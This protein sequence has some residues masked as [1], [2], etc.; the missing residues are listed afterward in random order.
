MNLAE[1]ANPIGLLVGF[2]LTL[3]V[4][5]YIFGDNPLFR[6]A[7]H[8]FIGVAAAYVTVLVVNNIVWNRLLKPVISGSADN[9]SLAI[10]SLLLGAWLMVKV[11]PRL[12][13]FGSPVLAYLVGVGAATAIGGAVVGTIVPQVRASV[14]LV[15]FD[16]ASQAG[17]SRVAWF[18]DA[19]LIL[20]GT[21]TTLAFFHFGARGRSAQPAQQPRVA[22]WLGQ[23]GQIF[24]AVTFGALFAGVYGAALAALVERIAFIWNT[25]WD[26]LGSYLP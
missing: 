6:V 13:R 20:V 4:L 16:I 2:F 21:V 14:N 25:I 3:M 1:L 5:S 9:L 15:D 11:S 26:F 22:Q 12:S 19:V 18:R 24:I 8:V 10:I 7:I 17:V 23:I